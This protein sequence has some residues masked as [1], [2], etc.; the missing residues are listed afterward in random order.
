M[1]STARLREI[2]PD[3][4]NV[5][6]IVKYTGHYRNLA[7][8]EIFLKKVLKYSEIISNLLKNYEVGETCLNNS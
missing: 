2:S 4:E 7:D 5:C 3:F 6:P 8:S 1:N